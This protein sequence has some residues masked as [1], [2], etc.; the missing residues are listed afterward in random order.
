METLTILNYIKQKRIQSGLVF[1]M[2][3][4]AGLGFSY[5]QASYTTNPT[6]LAIATELQTAGIVISNPVITKDTSTQLGIFSNGIA[7]ASLSVDDG[8]AFTTSSIASAFDN[9]NS[10]TANSD[11]FEGGITYD[12]EDLVNINTIANHD[13]V[14]FEFDFIAQ[15]NYKGVLVEYQFGSE[16]YPD[17]VGS[18]F[19]DVFGFF[20]SDPSGSD[21]SIP[22][23]DVNNNNVYD[24]GEVP[25]L[26]L[27]V[28]PG[29]SN[30]VS[31]NNV[32]AGF[33]G[34]SGAAVDNPTIFPDLTQA[35]NYVNNGHILDNDA[36]PNNAGPVND[37]SGTKTIHIEYNGI[38]KKFESIVNLMVGVTY[39]MK[40]AIADVGDSSYDSGVFVSSV[41]G[42]PIIITSDD[43]GV[44]TTSGGVAVA[45]VLV[46]DEVGGVTNPPVADVD[47]VEVSST[48][49]GVTLNTSTGAVNVAPGT[50][51]GEYT[52]VYNTCKP[53]PTNC[54]SSTVT[55]TVLLDS[56][57]DSIADTADLDDDNDG[58]LDTVEYAC[59]GASPFNLLWENQSDPN[60]SL[61]FD[62]IDIDGSGVNLN[63]TSSYNGGVIA[64][65][66]S[67]DYSPSAG[68]TLQFGMNGS[69]INDDTQ[70]SVFTLTFSQDVLIGNPFNIYDIDRN[71]DAFQDAIKIEAFDV[72]NNPVAISTTLGSALV[73]NSEGFIVDELDTDGSGTT[74]A[75]NI[76]TFS[77][78]NPIR[79]LVIT[80][81]LGDGGTPPGD[82]DPGNQIVWLDDF[83]N[84]TAICDTDGDSIPDY[85]DVDADNDGIYDVVESGGT[86]STT[87]LGQADGAVGTTPTT[88]GIP[89]SAGT[90]TT[91]TNTV[92]TSP[93]DYLNT[94]SD[95]DGC[96]DA[97]EAYNTSYANYQ[98]S[99]ADS[100]A[101]GTYGGVVDNTGVTTNGAITG[102]TYTTDA[103]RLGNVTNNSAIVCE[104]DSDGDGIADSADLDDDNDGILD[105]EE[106]SLTSLNINWAD[107]GLTDAG[108]S[109][110]GGQTI[111][112]IGAVLS[113]PELNGVGVT[114]RFNTTGPTSPTSNLVGN[115]GSPWLTVAN[116]VG[117]TRTIEVSFTQSFE[118]I[119]LMYDGQFTDG[120]SVSYSPAGG[121]LL[122]PTSPQAGLTITGDSVTNPVGGAGTTTVVFPQYEITNG[123][124][125]NL[126]A[127]IASGG[128]VTASQNGIL[129]RIQYRIC[130]DDGD[131]IENRLDVDADNDG[132]YDV[133]E[134]GGTPSTTNLGEADGA[135]GT[136]PTT[137]G[138][139][140]SAGTG[141]TPTNTVGTSPADY[142]NTESDGDGCN[143]ANEAYNTS[144]ANYQSSPA[145]SNADGTYGGVVDN[146]GVT[147]NGAITGLTYTTDATRLGN[148]TNSTTS[149]CEVDSDGDGIQDTADLD[150]DNDGIL[151][152]EECGLTS[153]NINWADLGL[154]DAGISA[155]GGQTIADIGAVLSI[156]ELNGVGVTVRFNTTGPTSPTS[157]LVGNAGSPWLT[158]ANAVGGTRTIEV[159]FTQSFEKIMLMYDGQFTDGESVSY[160]PAGG[161]LLQPTSPQAGLTITGDSVTN[162]VGGAGTTT[163]VFPQ[164]EI[165][166]GSAINL[167]AAIASGGLVT[168]SQN[169]ILL[170]IQYRICDD[171][172]DGIEN[173]LDVDADNDGI[174]DVVESGGTPSTTNLG[175]ADG[176]VGTTPT[177]RGIPSSAGTGT[178]P[179]NTVGTSPADYLNTE[180][181]GDGCNDANEAYNTSYANYQSSPAD[182]NADG[183]YGGVVD[184]TGVTTNGAITGLTYTTDV[185][186]LGNVTNNTAIVCEP[187]SD[188]DGIVDSADLDDD[189]DGIKDL[190]ENCE[191][192]RAQNSNGSWIGNTTSTV[193]YTLP[194][195]VSQSNT[196]NT[197][198]GQTRYYIND[199]GAGTRV[200]KSGDIIYTVTFSPGVPANEIG[201]YINDFDG[202]NSPGGSYMI[203]VNGGSAPQGL[204]RRA[205]L[206]SNKMTYNVSTG[207]I[208]SLGDTVNNQ[209]IMLVGN[210]TTLITELVVTSSNIGPGDNV[211]YSI[212][213]ALTCDTDGDGIADYLDLDAD[214]DGIY[215][216]VESG[217]IVSL[218]PGQEGRHIDD[219]N[220][221]NNAA[222]NGVP[223]F[224]NGGAGNT[225][226]DTGSDGSL[227]YLTLDSDGDSCSDANEAY[228]DANADGGDGGVYNPSNTAAEPLTVGAGTVN[229]NG[230]VVAAAY[231]DPVDGDTNSTDDYQQIGGPD[232][233]GDGISDACDPTFDDNDGD[234]IGDAVDLDGDNDGILDTTENTLG[235]N[236]SADADADGIPNYQDFDNN[237]SATAPV[238]IDGNLDG[239][240]DTLDPAFDFDGDGVSNHLDLDS[241]NDGITD[242]MESGQLD[243]GAVDTNQDGI[244]DGLPADF[245]ANGLANAIESNDT[246][247]ATTAN[248]TSTDTD[249]NANYI[250]I[251]ADDDGI[252]DNIEG[253]S[254]SGYLPP[255]G[256]DTDND[257]IDDQYDANCTIAICGLNGTPITPENTDGLADGADY[258]DL[259]SDEDGE[260][261]TI[262]AYDSNDDGVIDATDTIGTTP[263]LSLLGTDSDGDG[264]DDEFDIDGASTTNAGGS[265]NGGQTANNPFP[266]TDNPGGDPDW[267]AIDDAVDLVIAKT[268]DNGTPNEGSNVT[269]TITVTNNGAAQATNVVLTDVLPTGVTY[270]S[271]TG[272][273]AYVS[274]TGV[275]TVGTINNTGVATL[276]IVASVDV[277]TSGDTITNTV[278]GVSLDQTDN[279]TTPDDPSED[280]VVNN[281]VDL[282]V[283]KT[284]DNG[285]PNEGSNVTYTITVT[286]NGPAQA[287]NV[288]LTDVL[289]AGVT[290]VSATP[291][292]DYNAAVGVWTVG[293]INST[294]VATLNIVASVDVGTSGD[295]IT[296]TVTGVSLDQTD[297]NTTPD[298][299]SEDIVVNNV[300]DLVVAK[301]V[302]NGTPNE[303]SNVTYTITVTN[304]GPAQATSVVLTDVL[305]T[306]VTYVSDTGSGAYVSATG[307]WT[308]G[309]INSTGVATLN[310]VASVDVG[311]SGDT[312]TNTVTG[313]SLDQTDNNTTPDDPIE[314]I[315]VNNVVD[316]VVAKTVDNGTPNEG[317]NV[318]Y[319][320]TVTNN[321]PAQATSVV[322]T[323][324]LPT[325]VTYVSDT[326]SGAYVSATG[327]WTV[328]TINST[329]VATLNIVASVDV[330]TSGDTITNT[331]TGVSLDQT[332]N[333]TTPDD[334]SEDIVV[335]NVV[336]LVVAKTVDNGTPNEGSNVTYTITVTNNGPAQA[337]S[338][339]LIDVLPTGVTYVSDTGSG[340]YVSATGVWTV[341]TIN[342]TGVA[343]LDIVASVDVGT[344][345]DTITNTVTGVSLD[346]TDNNTTPDD[347]S[348]DIVVNNVVDLVVAKTVDNGTPN[349]GSN[350]TYTITVTNNGPAQATNVVLTDVLPAGVTFVS[351]TPAADYNA[352]VGVWTV[353]TINSTG[354]ATLDIVAS[355]DVGTSGDTI[356]NTVTGVSL[357]QTDNNTTPDDPSEDI[358]V[359]NVV[360]LVVAKT[361]D[362][363]TPNEGS[364]VT[365]TITV[366]NNGPA[367]ATSVVLTDVL[368]TG[369]TYVSDTGSGA[370]VSATGVWTVGTINSTGVATLNIVASVD[371]GTSGDTIT[372]TVTGV[373]LDQT[374]NNTTPDDP[375]ED[376]VVNNVVD[377]VVAKTVDN[378]TP[379]EGSNVTYTITVTNNGPAQATSVVLTDVLP[380]GVTYVSD[381][382]SG[383]YVSAT[384]VWTVGTINSTGVA[385]LNIV[386]S[387]DVGTSG[388][389]ITNTV[390]GVSLDQTDNNTTPDDPSE[391]IVVNNVVD[392]VVAKTVDNGTPNEGSNVTYTITVTNNGPAQATSVVLI[393]VLPTGVT[394]VSDTGSGAYVSATGVWTVGTINSTGV[395]TL[396]IVASVDVGTSGDT[397]TNT[398]TGVSLDQ[399]DNNTT[400]DDPS[401]DI[402]VNNVVD[403]VVAKTVDNGTPNE[404]S[405]VTYTITVT[406]NGP[407][408]ATNVVL[409]DVLPAGVTFVSATP[410]VDYNAAVGVWTV[411]TINSTG[412]ATLD[413]VASVDV[414]TSGDTITNTVTGV[415]LDQTDNNTTPDDPSE[416]IVV[417][418][419]VDLVVA[420]TVDN[421]TPNEGSNVT[422]TITVTNNGPAQA[423]SVVLTD[424]LP[425]GVTY[426]SDTGSGAYVS[427][428]GVWT[429]GTINSTGVATLNIVAS[430]DVGTSGDTITN[431][432]TGVSLDQT[433]NN[434]TPDDPSEDIVVNNVVDLVVAKTVDNG[435]PNEGSNVTYTITVTNNGPAQA[436]NVVLTDVLPTG[437]TYVS[438][439]G[440]GAYVS[441]TGVWTVGTINSTG[442][443]TLDIVASVDV[444]TS[445]DTITNTVTG[446]SLDQTDNNTTP[447]DPSEDIVVN[448]VVDLVVAKTVDNGTPNEGSNVTYTITVTNNG[449]AQ[450]TSVVLT[451]VLPAGVTYVSDTGSGAYVSATGVWTVGTINSTGVATLNIVA[452]VDVGTSGDTITNTVTGVSLDQTDNNTTPDDPSE[453]I[454]VNNVVDLVVAKTVDNG[455]PN[456]GSNVTYT[457]TVT[458]NGPAQATNVVLTDVLPAGVT[459]VSATPAVDYN[460]AVG[461]WTV[462]TIN[463]TG[464]ATLDIVASVD[465][466]T[467][468][469]TITNTV[470]GVSLDQTDNNTTPDD[471]SEDIVV[472]NVV[473]LVVAK[474][475]DNGTPNEGSNVTYTITVTNNGPAQATSVVLTDVLPTGV[476][477]VSDTGS[478]AYVSATGVWTVGTINSTGVATLNIVASVDVGTSGDTIT[479]TVTGVSLDQTDNNTTP[480]DPSEDIVVNNV[481]DLVVAKT[482]D[483]GTPNEGSNVTYTITVTNNGPA[484]ATNVVLTDVLPTG[485]TY[486]SDTGSGAYVS[487]TGVWTVGTINSTGV[488]TLDIVA[489]V[490]VGT[491]GDT[492]TNTVTGVSLDQTDNN[493]TPDDPSEDI[494]V[495]NV[496][497]L[498]VA[499]TVDNGT[500]NE[501][502]NVTYTITVTNNGPAQATSVVLTDVLP[503]GV[504]YVSDTGS[505][506]YV[507]ATGVWTVGT[508]NSTGVAT[509]NIV[510]SVD[511]GTSGDTITNTV[512]GVSLDQTDNN[513]T[514]DDPSE[515]IVVNN[516]VDLVVAKTVDNGT[517]N[518][519]S[520][521]TYTITVTNNG[522]AQATSVVLTDV[523]P[524]GVT[525]VSDTGSGAYVSATGV[526][527]VGTINSTGVA[528]LNIVASV[529]VGTSGDT[530]TNTVT[531]VSLDQTDNDTTP[532]DPS[533]DIVVNNDADLAVS[534][535]VDNST[536]NEGDTITYTID[537][538]NNGVA[539][540]TN[541]VITDLLP[542]GVTYVNDIPSQGSYVP[543][544]GNWVIGDLASGVNTTLDIIVTIDS[545][546]SGN[547]INNVITFVMDQNDPNPTNN[548]LEEEI[549]IGNEADLEITKTVNDSAPTEGDTIT[550]TITVRNNGE[551]QTTSLLINDL[552]PVGLTYV[553]NT[554]SLGTYDNVT[555]NWTIGNLST[556]VTAILSIDATV[557]IGTSGTTINNVITYTMDQ[558]DPDL[559]NNDLEEEINVIGDIDFVVIKS[560][561]EPGPYVLGGIY[562]YSIILSNTG[563]AQAT[564][565]SITDQLPTGVTYVSDTP[566]QGIFDVSTGVWTVGTIPSGELRM[567]TISFSVDN[568][569]A[570]TTI[571][572]RITDVTLDQN[573][574]NNTPDD[575]EEIITID[576]DNDNDGVSDSIDLDD[577]NDGILDTV[578][579]TIDSDGDGI[580]DSFDQDAD[581]D[582]IPDNVE[583]QSTD[584]YIPP[585]GN[586]SD[587]DGLDDAYEGVGNEGITPEN[588][589]GNDTP[590]YLDEDS[591]NDGIPDSTEGFDYDNDGEP[592]T[593]P[594][595]NDVDGDGLDDA[596]DGDTTGYGDP[597]G[598]IVDSNPDTDLNNTDGE[599]EPDYRDNDDDGD[600]VDTVEENY[601]N[602]NDPSDTDTDG[603]GTPDYLDT[604]DDNDGILTVDENPDPNGDGNPDDAVD[605]D[606]NGTPDYLEPNGPTGEGED[607]ITVFTGMSPNGDGVND[608]FIISGIE[609]LENTLEIYNRWGVK[610]YGAKNYGRNDNFFR[611]FSNGRTT[612]EETDQLPVGTYYYVLEYVLESGEH[613]S[614]AGYLYINR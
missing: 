299:P 595:G 94:D 593:L 247:T 550:Y 526:W 148:V 518:E 164:Y 606:G 162:P 397:I 347:P 121:V 284:V 417:N 310:I 531:G 240:C 110:S 123:S 529:D 517:P 449:P 18:S 337:T 226:T 43:S 314:N 49:P 34:S 360:D 146:T 11:D 454:V 169:G 455:T 316:L 609:R 559:T 601:D 323:D 64:A 78:N 215:D 306:G 301:T 391:D 268:V 112:D 528:T 319:T 135:V 99:P 374:D 55:V 122:Q 396:D 153:L 29:T 387:V 535:T 115:A 394:Y 484:Q 356:T 506:A 414:G 441:A 172:G 66:D 576:G 136:T 611:G 474:T 4:F 505:G 469:D 223:S 345:G 209:S 42:L 14:V 271:D 540:A 410:A 129:L 407:A 186:R 607:G 328:G 181:D 161:V 431:T 274:A 177:T 423:T 378:G 477:Y 282:V 482:V 184:N 236:P 446:V 33:R 494:V 571:T 173:R 533:E 290:F 329:G 179:T 372:N 259:N 392:L 511:V 234:G 171:D 87:N 93:A 555:G 419:V 416:D 222:T 321:G 447:D 117:G 116:A 291:A 244:I 435:T 612:I 54:D 587:G 585:S 207:T 418:N 525:Y 480:D 330:G 339:V 160:S 296:N 471:P 134:S 369:V 126:T 269:Y 145:D 270:V 183:T 385:T 158:V 91:P 249:G 468:G 149:V 27:A 564:N 250:D 200:A 52:L 614:K 411:G 24:F 232:G 478:G 230:L 211:A 358:V 342:S 599:D 598:N 8:V 272:S 442:V 258:I 304:N 80:Y 560:I 295:T 465:V 536:P 51:A 350:V 386:A 298:D 436:T 409:T 413:I 495:N 398:V 77:I 108:I 196:M 102:L 460:A 548:D 594:S 382:G 289:P 497:D 168:A 13:V 600:G 461:V 178:T 508:I 569:T 62:F 371:V 105:T 157:N 437:V 118:K 12:D 72:N 47:L 208:S 74:D 203:T 19:N 216:V 10:L 498:V 403:L 514:P 151:D 89:S 127:A 63:I 25:A 401:E 141:T 205:E 137:R 473:D 501:G 426:V 40:I 79:S 235:V 590:D 481:V 489:S 402:V 331:V 106:C 412:V 472:N 320:I 592:D 280:I 170:R 85:L 546:T 130:D 3:L 354:V 395:A 338:V 346:Q 308:V 434:T 38:T 193:T 404:G 588:T 429:V 302:D 544:S 425:T 17:Y 383:A 15:P 97:N 578:E 513:T 393:D 363:G 496:V 389:T 492:I 359:N 35:T 543:A 399:T 257:G 88:N 218:I 41:A 273:G 220:N 432:V 388:D 456:E 349:E 541:L 563:P 521:V 530:I 420:K 557:D 558:T 542:S 353:G 463:S 444:G 365:Y 101:D 475:V 76:A 213:G 303:G 507:S 512:T 31:I 325:G 309:T 366:T 194:G 534:K 613:K 266:D 312:I 566:D 430:V 596:Y 493:T 466:G 206:F 233:D 111:A 86:P 180:S 227:D 462:G 545:G 448:N 45:N 199:N 406:N 57:G 488:A 192:F 297:N 189:N 263:D 573:D 254:T 580:I 307:V 68:G 163:V 502:S 384:G 408:Q 56:D 445:G 450:A 439:T 28:V 427:A 575:L 138:I 479:N 58:I 132:I 238:C 155:S 516:V 527:T 582:G 315:V 187:D 202:V 570:G 198:D 7:D 457:I 503:A 217:G 334:P 597:N 133:V 265:N 154:T 150:D 212:F 520:N 242:L 152:T 53:S 30:P 59:P 400:P 131:G 586:D 523:L 537:V 190:E 552:L 139:P 252:V 109:A 421:G 591:D 114:V 37:N 174:Y 60:G 243:N 225:P 65:S 605:T 293:T 277:G 1:F 245:G 32:N 241:D 464:V 568:N 438:D 458:N 221:I 288:V 376:I 246:D 333:N 422:Y 70:N 176:A 551:A 579:G 608:V 336:D 604:D 219:D 239:I 483:N 5:A 120:E 332:D 344:S 341:G 313:V 237:G 490:D 69:D 467:S 292:A 61:D 119:M 36:D 610:V 562:T 499:K 538:T 589:D 128:L 142:L 515:D 264:L 522:P 175:E 191:G 46:N 370:Y 305:P 485:V 424:V 48:N 602:D 210:S 104:P 165:T 324:V 510:A 583:A 368:P 476:T 96:N 451:D 351:A 549:V 561:I 318:T 188:G 547:T 21:P 275:W 144:Y 322:L 556:G 201:F 327:V 276:D 440:S 367:Q 84:I 16:E 381:T 584:G 470:T 231:T 355:V 373:S 519:G 577:D 459:F 113:I 524:T 2:F 553:S 261:D 44:S 9:Q 251:D 260:S 83:Q 253:Q 23:G 100:N 361:V 317:S 379:N 285:T 357:D 204:F 375:S 6:A 159:S 195:F 103:T 95:D 443:A 39:R 487:A 486:V 335:N 574:L 603:D 281:V 182:S 229:T 267:R 572:N 166:N 433:D 390:T 565:V 107:L 300:V 90:G 340:A 539:Q 228:A 256:N 125:I 500:P 415:S 248:P 75:T 509:L 326:G 26:N 554:S 214:N 262:E 147:T 279:N 197:N 143:D 81:D 71:D 567:L 124:A 185:T 50:P 364:N 343:T 581:N 294:G 140:S 82:T 22:D 73:F 20:V 362:N 405:N 532:D 92:G 255:S 428:T 311:T 167:T 283:A 224:A 286:N 278:T 287:T 98:S 504:T 348:E 67:P 156:P 377:L 452:S 380:T 453:D 491:S 352:A